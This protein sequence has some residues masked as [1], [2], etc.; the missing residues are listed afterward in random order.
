VISITR[1]SAEIDLN[2]S[3]ALGMIPKKPAPDFHPGQRSF[4]KLARGE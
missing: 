3:S 2:N 4:R 1:N